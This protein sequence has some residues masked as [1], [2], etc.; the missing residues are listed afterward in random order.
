MG[1]LSCRRTRLRKLSLFQIGGNDQTWEELINQKTLEIIS[2]LDQDGYADLYEAEIKMI[3]NAKEKLIDIDD[4]Y[5]LLLWVSIYRDKQPE[6]VNFVLN[7]VDNNNLI[8]KMNAGHLIIREMDDNDINNLGNFEKKM[9]S[10]LKLKNNVMTRIFLYKIQNQIIQDVAESSIH[11]SGP[12]KYK[13]KEIERF[14][15]NTWEHLFDLVSILENNNDLLEN[16]IRKTK[17]QFPKIYK[18]LYSQRMQLRVGFNQISGGTGNKLIEVINKITREEEERIKLLAAPIEEE[19]EEYKKLHSDQEKV[20]ENFITTVATDLCRKDDIDRSRSVFAWLEIDFVETYDSNDICNILRGEINRIGNKDLEC[21]ND[22]DPTTMRD[23][24]TFPNNDLIKIWFP[25]KNEPTCYSRTEMIKFMNDPNNIRADWIQNREASVILNQAENV[26]GD[27]GKPGNRRY[28][29]I[30]SGSFKLYIPE[31]SFR[32]LIENSGVK[33]FQLVKDQDIRVGNTKGVRGVS[34]SHGQ[35]KYPIYQ[36]F[37]KDQTIKNGQYLL[38]HSLGKGAFGSAS[39]VYDTIQKKIMAIKMVP[40]VGKQYDVAL[41]EIEIMEKL[42]ISGQCNQYLVCYD[43][44]FEEDDKLYIVMEYLDGCNLFDL[45]PDQGLKKKRPDIL[46][47]FIKEVAEALEY[48][49]NNGVAHKDIHPP[50]IVYD[51]RNNRYKLIDFGLSCTSVTCPNNSNYNVNFMDQNIHQEDDRL[52]TYSDF[53]LNFRKENPEETDEN[54]VKAWENRSGI[55][56]EFD[57]WKRVDYFALGMTIL[58]Q[59]EGPYFYQRLRNHNLRDKFDMMNYHNKIRELL[60]YSYPGDWPEWVSFILLGLLNPN[61]E[62]R[63]TTK[64]VIDY[65]NTIEGTIE[66]TVKPRYPEIYKLIKGRRL[67]KIP[68]LVNINKDKLDN[69]NQRFDRPVTGANQTTPLEPL[70]SAPSVVIPQIPGPDPDQYEIGSSGAIAGPGPD[71]DQS[72]IGS[73][74][75]APRRLNF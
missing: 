51:R 49:H 42:K 15:Q 5:N 50:N 54:I 45:S 18:L 64:M 48:M 52:L 4:I 69:Y 26:T 38:G 37:M 44:H 35:D 11:F 61:P 63:M 2:G 40:K 8:S 20:R 46:L 72:E 68:I 74:P 33:E 43:S 71:P 57:F 41:N 60:V 67:C 14:Y 34:D 9:R 56:K 22:N 30:P 13:S 55:K 59:I 39:V 1:I 12:L 66:E 21:E 10:Y 25:N 27:G 7:N 70:V 73:S 65:L 6:L 24:K 17:N 16:W 53:V 31:N 75:L 32:L 3:N 62:E 36:L 23:I 58:Q 19:F 29:Q 28:R 47:K